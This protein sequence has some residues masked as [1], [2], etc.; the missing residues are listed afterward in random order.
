[1]HPS[2]EAYTKFN[3]GKVVGIRPESQQTVISGPSGYNGEN[4]HMD[5]LGTY[6][7]TTP[8]NNFSTSH[9]MMDEMDGP[10][11]MTH[12]MLLHGSPDVLDPKL[13]KKTAGNKSVGKK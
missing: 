13:I 1:M 12:K 6:L 8:K 7:H 11:N 2:E 10:N 4:E 5:T 9:G 3:D